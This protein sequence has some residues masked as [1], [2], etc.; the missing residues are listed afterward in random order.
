MSS[1]PHPEKL[2]A[3]DLAMIRDVLRAGGFRGVDAEESSDAK[4][5]ASALLHSEL[6]N[7]TRTREALLLSL[8]SKR[9]DLHRCL[10]SVQDPQPLEEAA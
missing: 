3:A 9:E 6:R 2:D 4:R 7:G 5:A 1:I 10:R 8:Q